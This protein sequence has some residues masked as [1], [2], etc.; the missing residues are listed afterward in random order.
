MFKKQGPSVLRNK[1]E[2]K[3]QLTYYERD[4]RTLVFFLILKTLKKIYLK[5]LPIN[6]LHGEKTDTEPY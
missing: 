6:I 4:Q 1:K 5:Y 2:F 3:N